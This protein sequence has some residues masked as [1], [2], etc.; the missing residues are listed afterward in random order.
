ME[1]REAACG[2]FSGY[3][4]TAIKSVV[5]QETAVVEKI[6]VGFSIIQYIFMIHEGTK[7]NIFRFA[8]YTQLSAKTEQF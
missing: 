5:T 6:S 3:P 4:W 2:L 7:Y 8:D 1:N